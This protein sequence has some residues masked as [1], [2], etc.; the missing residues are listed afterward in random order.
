V[1]ARSLAALAIAI[2]GAASAAAPVEPLGTLFT[3]PQERER[4]ERLRRGEPDSSG[5][6]EGVERTQPTITG[7]VRRSDERN[8]VWI[9]GVPVP[10]RRRG[11]GTLLQPNIVNARPADD[12]LRVE[13]KAR[14]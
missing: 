1:R 12:T 14:P 11:S 13:P 8:T 10:V 4:L 3:T 9:D 5:A 7:F 6:T 2:A